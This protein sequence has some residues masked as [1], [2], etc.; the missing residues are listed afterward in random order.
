M[1]TKLWHIALFAVIVLAVAAIMHPTNFR[2]AWMYLGSGRVNDAILK[3]SKIY[4]RNPKDY[5]TIKMLAEALEQ[6]GR[7]DEAERLYARLIEIKPREDNFKELVR[8]YTWTEQPGKAKG[9]LERWLDFRQTQ[10]LSFSDDDGKLMLGDLYA[11]DLLY[12]E[13]AKAIKVLQMR[14]E[15]EPKEARA[16]DDDMIALYETV[17]D[18]SSTAALLQKMLEAN[19][20]NTYALE[21]FMQI[22]KASGKTDVVLKY[23][24]KNIA[25]SPQD[26]N[27]WQRVITFETRSGDL[28]SANEWYK[29]W[30]TNEPSNSK[31]RKKYVEWLLSTDQQKVA[32]AFLEDLTRGKEVDPYYSDTLTKLYEWNGVKDKLVPIYLARFEKDPSDRE[33]ARKL[34]WLLNDMKRYADAEKV[35]R[36][37]TDIYPGNREYSK[38]LVDL[39]DAQNKPGSAIAEL[40]KLTQNNDDP[41]L[42]K[43]LGEHYL[44][45]SGK[46]QR[47]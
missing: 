37:L 36:R 27:V 4:E 19:D 29:K 38:M 28:G 34:V 17:G 44:W 30:L 46:S 11:Y 12:Q 16:I 35:L 31:L 5:R 21:K 1:G 14:R 6:E 13:Y 42:L 41:K 20:R 22:A 3:L 8:F 39:Y 47:Q 25:E 33:N 2:T 18:L 9:A 43:S 26:Q 10:K 45:S 23:L 7:V 40:E 24:T 32:I 15:V